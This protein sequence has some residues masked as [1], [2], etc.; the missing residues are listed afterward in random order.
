[1]S[2]GRSVAFA[3]D[4]VIRVSRPRDVVPLIEDQLDLD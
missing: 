1:M 2:N 3:R 4:A